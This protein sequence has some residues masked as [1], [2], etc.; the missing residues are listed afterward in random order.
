MIPLIKLLKWFTWTVIRRFFFFF[1]ESNLS[2]N[3]KVK[4]EIAWAAI[5]CKELNNNVLEMKVLIWLCAV[6]SWTAIS[7][8]IMRSDRRALYFL[9]FPSEPPCGGEQFLNVRR[10]W[11]RTIVQ[12]VWTDAEDHA[13]A[14]WGS[15]WWWRH[16]RGFSTLPRPTCLQVARLI[17]LASEP[18]PFMFILLTE[19]VLEKW[20]VYNSNVLE[21]CAVFFIVC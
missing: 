10:R 20:E 12:F 5:L 21:H 15:W 1:K 4:D 19:S 8:Y 3:I 2:K 17:L 13:A 7:W 9:Y 18:S 14:A 16:F 6:T 11:S